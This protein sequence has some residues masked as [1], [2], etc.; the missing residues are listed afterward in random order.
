[1]ISKK[2]LSSVFENY[3]IKSVILL[4][5]KT[6]CNFLISGMSTSISLERWEYLENILRDLTKK[7]VAITSLDYCKRH[8]NIEEGIVIK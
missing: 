2:I 7:D 1:M 3:N 5:S 4:E 6:T 8:V